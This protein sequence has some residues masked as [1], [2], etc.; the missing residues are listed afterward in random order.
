MCHLQL[1]RPPCRTTTCV[2][3][4][5]VLSVMEPLYT[6]RAPHACRLA[7]ISS[8]KFLL[9]SISTSVRSKSMLVVSNWSL[10]HFTRRQMRHNTK[11][12]YLRGTATRY[13]SKFV[14]CFTMVRELEWLHSKSVFQ[15]HS[16]ALTMMP[17]DRPSPHAIFY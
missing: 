4:I 8:C 3:G 9:L 1:Q 5:Q 13:V 12:S 16:R 15:C 6:C 14:H 11:L 7:D 2:L 17:V 10:C